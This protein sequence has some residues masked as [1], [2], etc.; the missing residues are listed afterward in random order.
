MLKVLFVASEAS[1][2]IK[3]GGLGD[4]IYALPKTLIENKIDA[5]VIIPLYEKIKMENLD[6]LE[7]IKDF[8]IT[9]NKRKKNV[10]LFK[11]VYENIIYYFIDNKLYFGC[12]EIYDDYGNDDKCEKHV[13]F[14]KAVLEAIKYIDFTPNIIHLNDYHTAMIPLIYKVKYKKYNEYKNIKF[15]FTI[16]NLKYQG[17]FNANRIAELLEIDLFYLKKNDILFNDQMNCMKVG[18]LFSDEITTVS[19]TYVKE[20]TSPEFGEGLNELLKKNE[21]KL[22]GII[23]GID[24]NE[25]NPETDLLIFNNYNCNNFIDEKV[26]NKLLLQKR[27]GLREDENIIMIG[28]VSRLT[29]MKGF[30]IIREIFE[31]LISYNVQF[32]LLGVGQDDIVD[33]FRKLENKYPDKVRVNI[34]FS[35]ELAHK[36]YASADI[37]LMPSKFE[38]CG[39]SQLIALR[40][41][42]IPVVRAT[43]GLNDTI[44]PY[45]GCENIGNGFSFNN[46]DADELLFSLKKAISLY[47]DKEKWNKLVLRAMISDN[48]FEKSAKEYIKIYKELIE[49]HP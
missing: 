26:K 24:Y 21:Y 32:V 8:P 37:Y 6:K 14:N 7:F 25:N 9:L 49:I 29:E 22:N 23:N 3:T 42:T 15:L 39:I 48:S 5:R 27:M 13:F 20:I 1:P 16:H 40:Y 18:V 11:I 46:Y 33:S 10:G 2:F 47:S 19:K 28:I 12:G 31:K 34:I 17:I 4:V 30:D 38:P 44:E 41:G 43:G 45:N 36:I 35:N